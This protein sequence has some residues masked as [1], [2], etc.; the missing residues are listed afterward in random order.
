MDQVKGAKQ[1]TELNPVGVK[2][3][4]DKSAGQEKKS[5]EGAGNK[6]KKKESKKQRLTFR[7]RFE[8][9][10]SDE[11]RK[12]MANQVALL[13]ID[14][15]SSKVMSWKKIREDVMLSSDEFHKIIRVS[16]YYQ[17]TMIG[18]IKEL[19]GSGWTYNGDLNKLVGFEVP[20]EVVN[21]ME[22][23]KANAKS[24]RAEEKSAARAKAKAE[25]AS[26][27]PSKAPESPAGGKGPGNTKG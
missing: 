15:A 16:N 14:P 23:A 1:A 11:E 5:V 13:R 24:K 9:D 17:G 20:E 4:S 10:T 6:E 27:A 26:K 12:D 18:R 7:E 3:V 8:N 2:T 19:M 25:E 22:Q 21:A